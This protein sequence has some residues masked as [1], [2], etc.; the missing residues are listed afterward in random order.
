MKEKW[1]YVGRSP[2]GGRE[3][4]KGEGLMILYHNGV[5][6]LWR[7]FPSIGTS[8]VGYIVRNKKGRQPWMERD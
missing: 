7:K 4:K 2:N 8:N 3:F 6:K 5:K 1:K